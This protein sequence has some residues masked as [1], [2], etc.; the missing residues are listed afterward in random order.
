MPQSPV[1][2][3]G[4]MTAQST[5]GSKFVVYT[6][7]FG[8]YDSLEDPRSASAGIRFICFTDNQNVESRVWEIVRVASNESNTD[9]NR[10]LKI[11]PHLYLPAHDYSL[12]IDGNVKILGR[13]DG[14]F[15]KYLRIT[16][17]AAPRHPVRDCL[18]DEAAGLHPQWQGR[19][20]QDPGDCRGLP[21]RRLSQRCRALRVPHAVP[22][23]VLT[24]RHPPDGPVVV[25]IRERRRARSDFLSLC[26]MESRHQGRG[27]ARVTEILAEVVP[28]R[29]SQR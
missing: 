8:D 17:I 10:R 12:Y 19:P 13:L 18:Y 3:R 27:A 11:N 1:N 20:G 15:D 29:I 2:A 23:N 28:P 14:L 22:P 26:S 7:I 4:Q 24:K 16:E 6:S 5:I 21:A 9:L 25:R